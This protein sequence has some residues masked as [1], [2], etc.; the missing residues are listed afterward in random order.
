MPP[1]DVNTLVTLGA[2]AAVL[3]KPEGS[4]AG[5]GRALDAMPAMQGDSRGGSFGTLDLAALPAA[6]NTAGPGLAGT[7][8]IAA[9][10]IVQH[11]ENIGR[12]MRGEEPKIGASAKP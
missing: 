8:A 11:R 5:V 1:S 7:L 3:P 9:I 4:A 12:L 2:V 10:V 6:A